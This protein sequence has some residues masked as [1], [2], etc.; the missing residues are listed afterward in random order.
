MPYGDL[1]KQRVQR[2]ATLEDLDKHDC[3]IEERE[4]YEPHIERGAIVYAGV[5]YGDIIKQAEKEADIVVWDGG[6]NDYPFYWPKVHVCIVDPHRAGNELTYYPGEVNVRMANIV[7]ISKVNTAPPGS[8][9]QVRK[10]VQSINP[11]AQVV[12][13]DMIITAD[14]EAK[15]PRQARA[16]RGG[17]PHRHP[18]G[19]GL[20]R[21]H[22]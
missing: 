20:R 3:T 12:E 1:V 7:V 17:W 21:S 6:N 19:H 13:T 8:V 22:N 9:E 11:W 16:S 14:D 5:D 10:N 2:F 4:D 18:R 15:T